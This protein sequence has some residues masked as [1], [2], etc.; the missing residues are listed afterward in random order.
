MHSNQIGGH[1]AILRPRSLLSPPASLETIGALCQIDNVGLR[2]RLKAGLPAA[3]SWTSR[4][5]KC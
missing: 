1:L 4:R 2:K 3:F 5:L